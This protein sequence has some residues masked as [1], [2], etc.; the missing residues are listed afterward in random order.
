MSISPV[1]PKF[2]P[3]KR[4][5]KPIELIDL[6]MDDEVSPQSQGWETFYELYRAHGGPVGVEYARQ[7]CAPYVN[8][9][10]TFAEVAR[11]SLELG[12]GSS[13][14]VQPSIADGSISPSSGDAPIVGSPVGAASGDSGELEGSP[15][16]NID[17][18]ASIEGE[19]VGLLFI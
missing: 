6:T 11:V 15:D 13:A 8:A 7:F 5:K 2:T 9:G 17:L 1:E 4:M 19:S 10:Y 12:L 16:D 18:D 3:L 14:I